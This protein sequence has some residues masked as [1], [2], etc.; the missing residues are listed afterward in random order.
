[1]LQT[2]FQGGYTEFDHHIQPLGLVLCENHYLTAVLLKERF[3]N[4]CIKIT[5]DAHYTCTLLA[6]AP[7]VEIS[8]SEG[9]V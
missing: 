8:V 2:C 9:G 1:M 5:H 7:N 6:A 3:S 4:T